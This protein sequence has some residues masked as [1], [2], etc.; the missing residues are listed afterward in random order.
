LPLAA[1][2]SPAIKVTITSGP[3]GTTAETTAT[4]TFEANEGGATFRCSLDG[5]PPATC[6][7]PI[8]YSGLADGDHLSLFLVPK[9]GPPKPIGAREIARLPSGRAKKLTLEL[10]LPANL[11]AGRYRL[12]ALVKPRKSVK[13]YGRG[14]DAGLSA[15]TILAG[16]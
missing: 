11:R 16:G 14:N 10:R 9:K 5:S 3:S 4:L 2:A 1:V 13:V 8:E 6:S 12:R 15:G 7:S